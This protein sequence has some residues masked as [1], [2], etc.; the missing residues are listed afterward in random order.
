MNAHG[1]EIAALQKGD[2]IVVEYGSGYQEERE[3]MRVVD[4]DGARGGLVD[5]KPVTGR[6]SRSNGFRFGDEIVEVTGI[7]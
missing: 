4:T 6:Y 5:T 2:V 1:I 7:R 3:V